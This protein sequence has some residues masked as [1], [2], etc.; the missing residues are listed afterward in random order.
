MNPTI[1]SYK[2]ADFDTIVSWWEDYKEC[3]PLE[4]MMLSDGSFILELNKVPAMSL[5]VLLTQSKE[6]SY[7]EGFIKNPLFKD[8]NLESYGKILWNHCFEYAKSRGYKRAICFS[9][10]EKL[11]N[12]Y[13]RFGMTKTK[14][15][16]SFVRVL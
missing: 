2:D 9:M 8:I 16:I 5:T 7:I 11:F 6:I 4:G 3:P 10:E 1:R 12:K 13:E 15:C 14:P